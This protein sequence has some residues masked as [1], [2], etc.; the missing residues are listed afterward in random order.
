M[1]FRL[2]VTQYDSVR[3]SAIQYHARLVEEAGRFFSAVNDRISLPCRANGLLT[4][5]ACHQSV[6]IS[7]TQ[8]PCFRTD[9]RPHLSIRSLSIHFPPRLHSTISSGK[10]PRGASLLAKT[11]LRGWKPRQG[12]QGKGKGLVTLSRFR[13]FEVDEEEQRIQKSRQGLREEMM[14]RARNLLSLYPSLSRPRPSPTHP[15]TPCSP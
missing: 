13:W 10:I 1:G 12:L 8:E 7:T 5:L 11:Q 15:T 6:P 2:R 3:L 9:S 4:T 14:G